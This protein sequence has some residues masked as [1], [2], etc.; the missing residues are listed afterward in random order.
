MNVAVY[1]RVSTEEQAER[2]LSIPFQLERCRYHAQGKGWTVVKEYVDAG[3]SARTDKRPQFQE[4]ISA[5]KEKQFDIILVHKL[6]RFSRYDYDFIIYEKLLE[7][8]GVTVESLSEPGDASTPAGYVSRRVMQIMSTW[9]SK[10]LAVEVKKG[11]QKKVENGGW[12]FK[13]PLGYVNRHDKNSSWIEVDPKNGPLITQAFRDMATGVW[14]LDEWTRNAYTRGYLSRSGSPIRKGSWS[15]I[16]HNRFYLGETWLKKADV[17]LKGSH[18]PLVGMDMFTQVQ[19]ILRSHDKF[20]QRTKR[21]DYLL[22]GLVHSEEAGSSCWAETINQ[23]R[24][25]YYRSREKIDGKAVYYNA[26]NIDS[27]IN[28]VIKSITIPDALMEELRKELKLCFTSEDSL[29][30]ELKNAGTRLVKLETME[31]NLQR[32]VIEDEISFA[33]FKEHRQRIEAERSRLNNTIDFVKQRQNL[34]EA[35]FEIALELANELDHLYERADFK[36]KRLLCEVL[37]KRVYVKDSKV[38]RV[39]LNAPFRLIAGKVKSSGTVE[40]GGRY[41]T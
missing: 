21:H 28:E 35:D 37:F 6:D 24:Q 4:M 18:E 33:D 38:S 10:N 29:K 15:F 7:D 25:S 17:P 14:T 27:Q 1:A 26:A 40:C 30:D 19:E 32:L 23:K 16:F 12:P 9:Y 34:V 11:M 31:K 20:K 41:R 5:A 39:E 36:E 13:A 3:E 22:R 8:Q 2:G